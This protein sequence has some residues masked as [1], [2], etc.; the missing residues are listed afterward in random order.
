ME[1][2]KICLCRDVRFRTLEKYFF[3]FSR[4]KRYRSATIYEALRRTAFPPFWTLVAGASY[5]A[6]WAI[7]VAMVLA[8]LLRL[9]GMDT[10]TVEVAVTSALPWVLAPSLPLAA[11][12]IWQRRYVLGGV[13]AAVL[14]YAGIVEGPV[15]WPFSTAPPAAAAGRLV[16]FDANV[17]QDNFNLS[18]IAGEIRSYHPNVISLEELTP[19]GLASLE[20]SGVLAGYRWSEVEAHSGASGMGVWSNMP[21]Q[22]SAWTDPPDQVEIDGWVSTPGGAPVRFDAVHVFAPIDAGQ[23]AEWKRQLAA[24][25]S[26]L[27]AEPRPLIVAGDFNAT[28]DDEPFRQILS[29]GLSDAAVMAGKGWEMTWP[30]DQAWVIPYL[31]ID[32]VLLSGALTVTSYRLGD[33]HGSDHHPLIVTVGFR[34]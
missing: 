30:R 13:S 16:V 18:E 21:A 8:C 28:S 17:A 32:H 20:R 14:L 10:R 6:G 5:V 25:R 33:G 12:G 26:H 31:R 4:T 3:V 29:D 22:L 7:A 34:K 11:V 1:D 27:A 23:P 24:V 19:Q 9:F 2:P 15:M